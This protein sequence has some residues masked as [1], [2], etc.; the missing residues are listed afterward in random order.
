MVRRC[1]E[2]DIYLAGTVDQATAGAVPYRFVPQILS[3][4]TKAMTP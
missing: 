1:P 3:V 4:L 2:L